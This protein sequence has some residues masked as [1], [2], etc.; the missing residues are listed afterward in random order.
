MNIYAK[1]QDDALQLVEQILPYF[2]PQYTLTIKPFSDI[3]TLT[4]DVPVTLS[5]VTFQDD[6]EG[7]VEQRRT[8]I[9][10]L[11]FEMKISLYGPDSSKTIIRDVR[12]NLFNMN[13]GFADSDMY[14]K[15]LKTVPNPLSVGA[16]S[17]YG[18]T[19]TQFGHPL[20]LQDSS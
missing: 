1:S 16:D 14:I 7:A 8:I 18:F 3:P 13:A 20:I 9:Y 11:E 10:T 17:D 5:G 2:A 6:F 19:E 12:N 4:E 15:T